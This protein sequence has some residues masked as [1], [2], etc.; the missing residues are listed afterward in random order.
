MSWFT[1][2]VICGDCAE[3]E[4]QIRKEIRDTGYY[5]ESAFDGCGYVPDPVLL[6][7]EEIDEAY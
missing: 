5:T 1:E 6:G 7:K 4:R 3:K 2:N